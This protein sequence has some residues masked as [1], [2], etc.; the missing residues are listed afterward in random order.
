[1]NDERQY[2][3]LDLFPDG[4]RCDCMDELREAAF[5]Y[6]LLN[7]GSEFG[8]WQQGMIAGY[9]AEVV[10]ALGADPEEVYASLADLWE[11]DYEDPNSGM[12]RPLKDW[13]DYFATERS[14]K[15]YNMLVEEKR[16]I[17]RFETS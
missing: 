1:M 15:L 13:A 12:C 9:P 10:D 6:L 11:D 17:R 7:P 4:F 16:K 5:E 2:E 14:V 8:D 3:G